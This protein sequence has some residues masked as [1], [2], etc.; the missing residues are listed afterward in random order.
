MTDRQPYVPYIPEQM[1]WCEISKK[2]A[3]MIQEIRLITFGKIVV[4]KLNGVIARTEPQQSNI[5][6]GDEEITLNTR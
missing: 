5:I 6:T 2:E 1:I 3:I 4:H